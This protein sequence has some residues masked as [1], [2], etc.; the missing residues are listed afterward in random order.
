MKQQF[1]DPVSVGR[2]PG[3]PGLTSPG[4]APREGDSADLEVVQDPELPS[5]VCT[6][7][8]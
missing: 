1:C 2:D 3:V 5:C 4:A 6:V 8:T 7:L